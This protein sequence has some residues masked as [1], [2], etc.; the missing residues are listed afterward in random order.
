MYKNIIQIEENDIRSLKIKPEAYYKW[1]DNVIRN[2]Q[3]FVVP[4]KTRMP[5]GDTDYFNVMP[6]ASTECVGVKIVTRSE[7]RRLAN[8]PNMD[9]D[10]FLYELNDLS[11][12]AIVDGAYITTM[13]TA[14]VA[15]HSVMHFSQNRDTIAMVGLGN[16]GTAIGEILFA[17]DK[18]RKFKVKLYKYKDQA[19][20]FIQRFSNYQ[21]IKF[22][23]CNSYEDLMVGSD[24][25]LSSVTY[26]ENDFCP[27]SIYTKGCT[28]IPVHLRGFMDCDCHF[29]HVITSDLESIKKFRYYNDFKRMSTVKEALDNTSPIRMSDKDRVIVYNLGL[30]SFDIYFASKIYELFKTKDGKTTIVDE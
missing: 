25:V 18:N 24:V 19:E 6:C 23:V 14:A 8:K 20:R 12:K 9:A 1:T 2:S 3:D 27:S 17:V 5:I 21:N 22:E 26:M 28:V 10:I 15:V 4:T 7:N 29:D 30:A 13:R 16:I 11:I